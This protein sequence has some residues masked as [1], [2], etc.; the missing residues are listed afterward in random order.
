MNDNNYLYVYYYNNGYN[1]DRTYALSG[2]F[3]DTDWRLYTFTW[4]FVSM[5]T[6]DSYYYD[7][8][9]YENGYLNGG[10]DSQT[11]KVINTNGFQIGGD[12]ESSTFDINGYFDDFR[13]YNRVLSQDEI[14]N[15]FDNNILYELEVIPDTNYKTILLQG[16]S[17]DAGTFKI[18]YPQETVIQVQDSSGSNGY[19]MLEGSTEDYEMGSQIIYYMGQLTT[20][21]QQVVPS[22]YLKYDT[23]ANNYQGGWEVV[24]ENET[25][26][27]QLDLF[28]WDN[29]HIIIDIQ[30]SFDNT[31][32]YDV[33]QGDTI[34][35]VYIPP[36]AVIQ[37]EGT[38]K[39]HFRLKRCSI[40]NVYN[41]HYE[42]TYETFFRD[43][44]PWDGSFVN[45]ILNYTISRR[46]PDSSAESPH[47]EIMEKTTTLNQQIQH[48]N[49]APVYLGFMDFTNTPDDTY[50]FFAYMS[51]LY[52]DNYNNDLLKLP[53]YLTSGFGSY[54]RMFYINKTTGSAGGG[55]Y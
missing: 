15:L 43:F 34:S 48:K 55:T 6:T 52:D 37:P 32:W 29:G 36:T 38:T 51:L 49:H 10:V 26:R 4:T 1:Y 13:I 54:T 46:N 20:N 14:T 3:D 12:N 44:N 39:I 2:T 9:F 25:L 28:Y 45:N 19:T 27:E 31:N 47:L 23:T 53:N 40:T 33:S 30:Y 35:F 16:T 17:S 41:N 42:Y 24:K 21:T 5:Q 11:I 50:R 7:A 8:R 22:G 18:T